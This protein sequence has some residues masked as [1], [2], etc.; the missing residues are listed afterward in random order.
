[1][2]TE[3][4]SAIDIPPTKVLEMVTR[5]DQSPLTSLAD[6][7]RVVAIENAISFKPKHQN[8]KH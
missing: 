6:R 4:D 2:A 5:L 1:M 7:G 8:S 3:L